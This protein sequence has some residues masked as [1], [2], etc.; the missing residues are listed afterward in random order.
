MAPEMFK[1]A[2]ISFQPFDLSLEFGGFCKGRLDDIQDYIINDKAVVI[3]FKNGTK[4]VATVDE[5]DTFDIEFGFCLAM[6]KYVAKKLGISKASYKREIECIKDEKMKD[7]LVEN[8]NRFTFKDLEKTR[9]FL[10]RLKK[11][12]GKRVKVK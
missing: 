6:F 8:F 4:T 10:K 1:P 11:T 3:F 5:R 7:Y 9:N 2:S 12:D